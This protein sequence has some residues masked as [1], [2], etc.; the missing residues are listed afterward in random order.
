MFLFGPRSNGRGLALCYVTCPKR[1]G[2]RMRLLQL[3]KCIDLR[4]TT[5]N[6]RQSSAEQ[7][8]VQLPTCAENAFAAA[9]HVVVLRRQPCSNR[10]ISPTHLA[11]SSKPAARCCSGRVGQTNG[12][13]PYRFINPAPHTICRQCQ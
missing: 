3:F 7:V 11:H 13:T 10:S 6:Y 12:R 9:L 1:N 8:C 4:Y 2:N 5:L